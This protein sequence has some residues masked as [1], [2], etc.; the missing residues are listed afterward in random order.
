M[1]IRN[2]LLLFGAIMLSLLLAE[3]G[4]RLAGYQPWTGMEYANRERITQFHPQRGWDLKQGIFQRPPYSPQQPAIV[5]TYLPGGMRRSHPQQDG[6][7]N[8]TTEARY[9]RRF[10][11]ARQRDIR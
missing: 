9:D 3:G 7:A 8:K 5:Y 4:L 1:N 6:I 11:D 10:L 2:L